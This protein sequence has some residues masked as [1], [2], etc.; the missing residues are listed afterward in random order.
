MPGVKP[1]PKFADATTFPVAVR[2]LERV[3]AAAPMV[4]VKVG[5]ADIT[6][7]PVPVMAFETSAFDPLENT[8]REAV[9]PERVIPVN[10]GV[11]PETVDVS[12]LLASVATRDEAVSAE[13]ENVPL[14]VRDEMVSVF[15]P[16]VSALMISLKFW[17][18]CVASEVVALTK[19]YVTE[20]AAI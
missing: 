18:T 11:R 19:V 4:P 8:G 5:D 9:R 3:I 17:F 14:M 13:K 10:P 16:S 15:E 6:T 20:G 2:V 7:L 12:C 1:T